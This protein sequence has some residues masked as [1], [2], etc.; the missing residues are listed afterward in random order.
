MLS[1]MRDGAW[2][3]RWGAVALAIVVPLAIP[4]IPAT[5]SASATP[6]PYGWTDSNDAY[7]RTYVNDASAFSSSFQPTDSALKFQ[8]HQTYASG[9]NAYER[10]TAKAIHCQGCVAVAVAVQVVVVSKQNL[11]DLN[12]YTKADA[13]TLHCTG[14]TAIADAIQI[15]YATDSQPLLTDGQ[16]NCLDGVKADF[17]ALRNSGDSATQLLTQVAALVTQVVSYLLDSSSSCPVSVPNAEG[18]SYPTANGSGL[19]DA[20]DSDA[21]PVVHVYQDVQW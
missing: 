6:D 17:R 12:Q 4:A 20:W 18:P 10:A 2:R 8:L 14:C 1:K 16:K 11:T 13:I 5:A 21:Q 9:I 15:V 7:A 3:W 19:S